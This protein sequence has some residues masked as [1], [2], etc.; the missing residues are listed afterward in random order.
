MLTIQLGGQ[1]EERLKRAAESAGTEPQT[2]ARRLLEE[3]LP[4]SGDATLA[5]LARWER[6]SATTDLAELQ[7]RQEEGERLMNA[8]A[9]N[10]AESEGSQA[11]K[12]WP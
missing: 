10:R 9:K 6:E 4:R 1:L 2:V 8:L 12:L 11:R 3:N 7:Q 5:L